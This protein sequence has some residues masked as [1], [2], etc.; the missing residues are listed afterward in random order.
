MMLFW[1]KAQTFAS[2][3]FGRV[4]TWTVGDSSATTV[5]PRRICVAGR[6]DDTADALGRFANRASCTGRFDNAVSITIPSTDCG[7]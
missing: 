2:A 5:V 7:G 1:G 6:F 4:W 3:L